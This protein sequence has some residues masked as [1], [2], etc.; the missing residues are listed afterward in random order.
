[1][2]GADGQHIG[3]D[4]TG[5]PG[6]CGDID[7][8]QLG[9]RACDR[10]LVA[11]DDRLPATT[12]GVA[13]RLVDRRDRIVERHHVGQREVARLHH[14]VDPSRHLEIRSDPRR[15]DGVDTKALVDDRLPRGRR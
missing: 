10:L 2:L 8:G 3:P 1:V 9:Q 6:L 11:L 12:V 15:I 4:V 14:R 7:L 5:D 13:D